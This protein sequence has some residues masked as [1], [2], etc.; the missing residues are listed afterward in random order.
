MSFDNISLRGQNEKKYNMDKIIA[1]CNIF[2]GSV[3]R[4][5][6]WMRIFSHGEGATGD[7]IV[8]ARQDR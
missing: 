2:A 1:L 7:R 4:Y 6:V 5:A 3:D 8:E